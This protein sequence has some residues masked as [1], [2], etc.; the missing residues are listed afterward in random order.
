M[1]TLLVIFLF[2]VVGGPIFLHFEHQLKSL[3]ELFITFV[4]LPMLV[5]I[6]LCAIILVMNVVLRPFGVE[7]LKN[8][9]G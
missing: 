8:R 5:L 7:L 1:R 9:R 6:A 2:I 4:F 3:H